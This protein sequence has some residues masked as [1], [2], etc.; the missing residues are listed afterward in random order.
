MGKPSQI[1]RSTTKRVSKRDAKKG[2]I[3][4]AKAVAEMIKTSLGPYGMNK[5]IVDEFGAVTITN[6]GA[7]I[8]DKVD[9]QHPAAKAMVEVAKAVDKEVGDGTTT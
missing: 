1:L 6:D 9:V 7:T 4:A 8:L 2:N 5:M 3:R